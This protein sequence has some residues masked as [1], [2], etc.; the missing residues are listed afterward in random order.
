MTLQNTSNE[1]K[2]KEKK[3]DS[4]IPIEGSLLADLKIEL[5]A[6]AHGCPGAVDQLRRKGQRC[7]LP[8]AAV[9]HVHLHQL[10]HL[11]RILLDLLVGGLQ[12]WRADGVLAR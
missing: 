4:Q 6:Q 1:K 10:E 3:K 2:R 11:Q 7:A 5:V 9:A 12:H 8:G